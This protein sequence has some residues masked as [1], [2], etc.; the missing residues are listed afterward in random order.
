MDTR[1]IEVLLTAIETGSFLK[2][3]EKLGY[4]QSGLTHMMNAFEAQIGL[5]LLERGRFGIRLTPNGERLLPIFR[6]YIELDRK[7]KEEINLI[8]EQ[9][10]E[11]IRVGAYASIAKQW[12]PAI[13]GDFREQHPEVE[14]ELKVGGMDDIYGWLHK[15]IIDICFASSNPKYPYEFLT[16]KK[17][18]F[19]A[20][21]PPNYPVDNFEAFPVEKMHN[22]SF[23]MPSFGIDCDVQVVLDAFAVKPLL[24]PTYVDNSVV[25]SL[26]ARGLG[27]SILSELELCGISEKVLTIPIGPVAFRQ[28]GIAARS[29]DNLSFMTKKFLSFVKKVKM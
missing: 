29:F 10:K 26:I 20:V 12:L 14:I 11:V 24:R 13:I 2:A 3:A 18:F 21:L 15:G 6:K 1:K 5:Q 25:L 9:M 8:H 23:F 27:V 22:V 28:L 16:L 4:T 7:M 17:D 19:R